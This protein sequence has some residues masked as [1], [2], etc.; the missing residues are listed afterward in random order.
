MLK[1]WLKH[2]NYFGKLSLNCLI[3]F[4]LIWAYF[5]IAKS[6]GR[7]INILN[8][9]QKWEIKGQVEIMGW[10]DENRLHT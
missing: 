6:V 2:V 8:A 5:E 1:I 7:T 3:T 9:Y 10:N 4:M